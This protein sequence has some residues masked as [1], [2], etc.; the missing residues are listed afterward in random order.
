MT[1]THLHNE[2]DPQDP[3]GQKLLIRKRIGQVVLSLCCILP[4][5]LRNGEA[6]GTYMR[7]IFGW[8]APV[9]LM[10]WTF[11]YQLLITLP[12]THTILPIAVPTL[13]LWM[14]DT[15][16]LHRGTWSISLGTK[17][18]VHLWPYLEIEEAVFFLITNT[19]VVWGATAYDNAVAVLDVF[20]E[21][22]PHVPGTPSPYLLL[23]GLFLSTSKYDNDRL[24]GLREA[25]FVLAR[26]SRSFYLAS[27]VFAGRLRIDLILL[28]GFCRV[29][30]DLI[31][32][33]TSE[34]EA[35]AW[36]GHFSEFLNVMYSTK[37]DAGRITEA[38]KPF[39]P[40]VQSVLR[41]LPVDKLPSEPLYMLLD[42][43]RMDQKF[44][45]KDP[46]SRPPIQTFADLQQYATC[47]AATIGELCLHLVFYHDPDRD[48]DAT[49]R[50]RCL[51]A[52]ARMGRALQYVNIVRDVSTD[53]ETG[54]CYIPAEWLT[55]WRSAEEEEVGREQES[56]RLRKKILDIA[57]TQYAE[58][59]DAIEDL[60][61]YARAGIRV[62]VESYMEIGRIMRD[63]MTANQPLNFDGG[64]KAGRASVPKKRRLMVG[65][66]TM[67]GWRGTP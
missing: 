52:G 38:L 20:P 25:L 55:K 31:D 17:L 1:A 43:F 57:F 13:Y 59:R 34:K 49:T 40:E 23:R 56:T 9:L 2:A 10:L 64:G 46:K 41:Q 19:L 14:V 63:R 53:A 39:P 42:G 66:Q 26:K 32:N 7:L 27:G 5:L 37:A 60:P 36:V 47:V 61:L 8:A 54:R 35:E 50:Q 16:A 11:A 67:R 48:T 28:Y 51:Q 45:N 4:I 58:N 44:M 18:G 24:K 12:K 33:V 29:A 65:W 21:H 30:D 3:V 22:F 62:A 15:L 6:K